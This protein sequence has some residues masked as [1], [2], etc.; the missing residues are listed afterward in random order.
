MVKLGRGERNNDLSHG[1]GVVLGLCSAAGRGAFN[2]FNWV[3][4][5]AFLAREGGMK[6]VVLNGKRY[7]VSKHCKPNDFVRLFANKI[8]PLSG[9]A[10][11]ILG[12]WTGKTIV[13]Q[14]TFSP[15]AE[16]V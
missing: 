9:R 11:N 15:D 7:E 1:P 16:R 2:F 6:T 14:E 3:R 5:W 8:V 12:I 13:Q 4:L 10:E